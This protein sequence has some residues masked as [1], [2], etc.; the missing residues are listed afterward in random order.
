MR[1]LVLGHRGCL[2]YV[3]ERYFKEIG[4]DVLTTDERYDY[5]NPE[6]FFDAI[7]TMRPD[8]I[9]N[10]IGLTGKGDSINSDASEMI[11]VNAALPLQISIRFPASII[12]HPS[13]D[14]VFSGNRGWYKV[15]D[16]PDV[17]DVYGISKV[18]GEAVSK[19]HN[20]WVIRCS[21]IGH[22]L[23]NKNGLLEW[24]LSQ[25]GDIVRG[26][27]NHKWNGLTT[28]EYM[29]CV[30]ELLE[31]INNG[32]C[33]CTKIIQLGTTEIHSKAEILHMMAKVWKKDVQIMNIEST[34]S[35]DRSL[36]PTWKRRPLLEQLQ[37]LHDWY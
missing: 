22:E 10:C 37:E 4:Y 17:T 11:Q 31:M 25:K 23:K 18:L 29:K 36:E 7:L 16:L 14:S 32:R 35:I 19:Y 6:H 21:I 20:S 8:V 24:F 1:I 15:D 5:C 9:I 3:G 2:G 12:I 27:T 34:T 13:T 26:Y 28:L 33:P 30:Y